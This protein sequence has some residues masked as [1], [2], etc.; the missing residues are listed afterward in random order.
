MC[1]SFCFS[2]QKWTLQY[3][4]LSDESN[5]GIA[6]WIKKL[7]LPWWHLKN[8]IIQN[9]W[10]SCKKLLSLTKGYFSTRWQAV[11]S[12]AEFDYLDSYL[13]YL[14]NKRMA[15][16]RKRSGHYPLQ[17]SDSSYMFDCDARSSSVDSR[18]H[19]SKS[20][21]MDKMEVV[22]VIDLNGQ[23]RKSG[24]GESRQAWQKVYN[25]LQKACSW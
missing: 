24:K 1:Q 9:N 10:K 22:C 7:L 14:F 3:L 6:I 18:H 5:S 17:S 25:D 16:Q 12:N 11:I 13:M 4:S 20:T 21:P 2:H 8:I 15:K 19:P 23:E